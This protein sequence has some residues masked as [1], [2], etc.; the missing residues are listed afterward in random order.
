M[1]ALAPVDTAQ[2]PQDP[3]MWTVRLGVPGRAGTVR[4]VV[5][6]RWI[7][8]P[9]PLT[10]GAGRAASMRTYDLVAF[11]ESDIDTDVTGTASAAPTRP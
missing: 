4:V 9:T 8:S 11:D 7:A 10:C 3:A 2:D 5:R 1:A 6:E